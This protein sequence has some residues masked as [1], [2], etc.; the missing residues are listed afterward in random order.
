MIT[1]LTD[2]EY[3][4]IIQR[5]GEMSPRDQLILILLLHCGLRN[6]ELCAMNQADFFLAGDVFRTIAVK[7]GHSVKNDSRYIPT[8]EMVRDIGKRYRKYF[9]KQFPAQYGSGPLFV[10]QISKKRIQV[11]DIQRLV[12]KIGHIWLARKLWPHSLRHTFAT[13]LLRQTNLRVVQQ[14][15]GHASIASTQVYTHPSPEDQSNAIFKTFDM[16]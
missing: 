3:A 12:T 15:L 14:L 9:Q 10:S 1:F 13:R 8:S 16:G 5:L 6:G 7:N 2:S 4:I 11:R